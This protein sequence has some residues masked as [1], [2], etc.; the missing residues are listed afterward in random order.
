MTE[1]VRGD[2]SRLEELRPLFMAL[3]DHHHALTPAWG[4]LVDD[5]AGWALRRA[6][7]ARIL[8]RG[9]SLWLALEGDRIAGYAICEEHT[10]ESPTWE[11]PPRYLQVLDLVLAPQRRHRPP[12]AG[13]AHEACSA[14]SR[15]A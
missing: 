7:Y 9:G 5:D 13:L 10:T 1:I 8:D 11:W 2:A 4:A 14:A 6:T 12:P 3:R 15:L